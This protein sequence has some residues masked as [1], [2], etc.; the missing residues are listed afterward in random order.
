MKA[1]LGRATEAVGDDLVTVCYFMELDEH[2]PILRRCVEHPDG[3]FKYQGETYR[4]LRNKYF[5]KMDHLIDAYAHLRLGYSGAEGVEAGLREM[6]TLL[7]DALEVC[8][9]AFR[10]RALE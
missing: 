5:C 9:K 6:R 1:L 4:V 8:R 10:L 2:Q 7:A 3:D